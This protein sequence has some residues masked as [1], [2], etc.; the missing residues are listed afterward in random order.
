MAGQGW[1][2]LGKAGQ[3]WARLD[4]A[5]EAS[6]AKMMLPR[7]KLTAPALHLTKKLPYLSINH[8]A[9]HFYPSLTFGS[10]AGQGRASMGKAEHGWARLSKAG[11]RWARLSRLAGKNYITQGQANCTSMH[12][13]KKA[14]ELTYL[15]IIIAAST[16][17]LV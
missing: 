13:T 4:K 3:G 5:G 11:H 14:E 16:F 10:K 15:S 1:A 7:G 6:R 2:R 17:P 8:V 12:L 9:S